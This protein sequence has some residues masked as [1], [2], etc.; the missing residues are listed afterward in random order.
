MS[1][2][3]GDEKRGDPVREWAQILQRGCHPLERQR[4]L[5]REVV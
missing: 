5:I 3:N 1:G 4:T 2:I